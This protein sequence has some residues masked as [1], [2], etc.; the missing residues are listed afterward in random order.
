MTVDPTS[1]VPSH[2]ISL[3]EPDG[4][5]KYGLVLCDSQGDAD[6]RRI[7]HQFTRDIHPRLFIHRDRK[8]VDETTR[9]VERV[10]RTAFVSHETKAG[11]S[12]G[13]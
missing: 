1:T 11:V 8:P 5:N 13:L 9:K 7:H 6:I 10:N 12:F 2:Q 3:E 4:S